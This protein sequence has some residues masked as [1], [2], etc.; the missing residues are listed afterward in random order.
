MNVFKITLA[1]IITSV[2]TFLFSYF[3]FSNEKTYEDC[4]IKNIRKVQNQEVIKEI[5]DMC[6]L[7][8]NY[9][10]K[11]DKEKL[12]SQM[13]DIIDLFYNFKEQFGSIIK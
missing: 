13:R 3:Y 7:R 5:K 2:L 12:N 4:V 10:E 11:I 1:I 9:E 8:H 6:K